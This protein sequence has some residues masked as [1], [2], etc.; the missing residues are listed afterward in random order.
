MIKTKNILYI[1][2]VSIFLFSNNFSMQKTSA[3]SKTVRLNIAWARLMRILTSSAGTQEKFVREFSR[4]IN[5]GKDLS[6]MLETTDYNGKTILHLVAE[7]GWADAAALLLVK[8]A[9]KNA[10]DNDGLTPAQLAQAAGYSE[11][12]AFLDEWKIADVGK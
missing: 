9:D 11:L 10:T 5:I 1:F 8:D 6:D 4:L 3:G 12:S 7:K 2:L